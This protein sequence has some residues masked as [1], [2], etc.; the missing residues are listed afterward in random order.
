MKAP[1]VHTAGLLGPLE[2]ET[3]ACVRRRGPSSVAEVTEQVNAARAEQPLAYRTLLSVL[4]NLETKGLVSHTKHGRAYR[5]AA[6]A[7]DEEYL[8]VRAAQGARALL[9]RFGDAAVAGFVNEVVADPRQRALLEELLDDP[10]GHH[11]P[12]EA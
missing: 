4:T 1:D 2:A 5:Y 8:A 10:G 3:L 7:T 12:P 11:A 9:A 6:T